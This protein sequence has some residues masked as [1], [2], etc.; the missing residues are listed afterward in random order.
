MIGGGGAGR[1]RRAE[2]VEAEAEVAPFG[3]LAY[4]GQLMGQQ[5][6]AAA[7]IVIVLEKDPVADRHPVSAARKHGHLKDPDL[8][9]KFGIKYVVGEEFGAFESSHAPRVCGR[10]KR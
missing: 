6:P 10:R 2:V 1:R 7:A 4:V 3:E 9:R 8:L 5:L